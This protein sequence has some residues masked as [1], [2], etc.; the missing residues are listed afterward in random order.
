MAH[1][2]STRPT[3]QLHFDF[4]SRKALLSVNGRGYVLPDRYPNKE[5]AQVAAQKFAFEKLGLG[6]EASAAPKPSDLAIW[7]H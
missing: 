5:T 6:Q 1:T 7:L 4:L 3:L 2:D